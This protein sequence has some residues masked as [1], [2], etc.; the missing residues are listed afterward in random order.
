MLLPGL[1]AAAAPPG[2]AGGFGLRVKGEEGRQP[3]ARGRGLPLR[4]QR[5]SE[6]KP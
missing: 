4:K 1:G 2:Q 6:L 3:R 5:G